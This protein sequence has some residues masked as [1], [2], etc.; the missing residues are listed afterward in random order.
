M[1]NK[2]GVENECVK[3]GGIMRIRKWRAKGEER[4]EG[5]KDGDCDK[6][7]CLL[8][9]RLQGLGTGRARNGRFD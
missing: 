6:V 8:W 4:D 9:P 1:M 2:T 3:R 5:G 7:L